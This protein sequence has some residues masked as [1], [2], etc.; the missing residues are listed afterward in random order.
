MLSIVSLFALILMGCFEALVS[1]H[2]TKSLSHFGQLKRNSVYV[3][4]SVY[5]YVHV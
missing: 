1:F 3:C 4:T 5:S 2:N